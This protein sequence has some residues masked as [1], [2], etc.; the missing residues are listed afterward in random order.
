MTDQ[1][2]VNVSTPMEFPLREIQGA[3]AAGLFWS[4]ISLSLTLPDI[5]SAAET[6]GDEAKFWKTQK[7]YVA[8]CE[9]WVGDA[10]GDLTSEDLWALRGGVIHRGQ[11]FGHPNARYSRII[12]ALPGPAIFGGFEVRREGVLPTRTISVQIFCQT[13]IDAVER[14]IA[15]TQADAAIAE[16]LD[17]LVRF[18]PEGFGID[19]VGVPV[20]A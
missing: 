5:C 12:F 2:A 19:I 20:I 3:Y 13:M 10:F 8:W 16:A 7:R 1:P 9:K 4:A 18:R 14:W 11:T 17:G 15:A 6:A